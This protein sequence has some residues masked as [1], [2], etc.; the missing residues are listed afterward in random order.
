MFN[1]VS[2]SVLNYSISYLEFITPYVIF[3]YKYTYI[4]I[5]IYIY[6]GYIYVMIHYVEIILM[7]Y[8]LIDET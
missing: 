7:F 4:Y 3:I 1:N 5:Y 6:V 2:K 8:D